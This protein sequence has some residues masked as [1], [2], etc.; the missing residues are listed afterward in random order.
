[1]NCDAAADGLRSA[2][3][4]VAEDVADA[5]AGA[6]EREAGEAGADELGGLRI[7]EVSPLSAV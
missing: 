2:P 7:H 1:M 4:V 3:E 6:D 5:D